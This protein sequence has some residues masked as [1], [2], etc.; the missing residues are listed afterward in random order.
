[1]RM[2]VQSLALLNA[3]KIQHCHEL[4]YKWQMQL[5]FCVTMAVVRS[6]AVALI[7]HLALP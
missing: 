4:W 5:I 2:Q 1:M 3:L 7:R 6:A